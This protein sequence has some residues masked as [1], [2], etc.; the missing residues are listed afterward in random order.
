MSLGGGDPTV[1]YMDIVHEIKGDKPKSARIPKQFFADYQ[2]D[3][4]TTVLSESAFH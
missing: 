4:K 2:R 1:Q 3:D